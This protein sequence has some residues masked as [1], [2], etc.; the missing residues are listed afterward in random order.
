MTTQEEQHD[1][2]DETCGPPCRQQVVHYE[3][4]RRKRYWEVVDSEGSLVCVTLYKRGA[5]EVI[6]RL[7]E[8][9]GQPNGATCKASKF[10]DAL[11]DSS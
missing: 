11:P 1:E 2:G 9:A 5:L 3:M 7:S 10:V 6:R 4:R 8:A